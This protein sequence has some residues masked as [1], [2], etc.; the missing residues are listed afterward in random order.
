MAYKIT[1][2][3]L[4][5]G[6]GFRPYVKRIADAM[7]I[8][9]TVRNIAGVVDIQLN[10]DNDMMEAFIKR[11][12][13]S[14][15]KGAVI[16]KIDREVIAEIDTTCFSI[17][18]SE[19]DNLSEL[20]FVPMDIAT[21]PECIREL[22]DS[23]NRRYRHPFIS[24]VACGPRYSI[25]NRTPYDRSN[26]VMKDFQMCDRCRAEYNAISD[27]R[28]YAQTIACPECGPRL[29]FNGESSN[30]IEST[31]SALIKGRIVAV[32]DTGGY[33]FACDARNA[34]AVARL[35]EIKNREAKPFAVMFDSID[36]IEKYAEVSDLELKLLQSPARPIVL[37]TKILEVGDKV[38][39]KVATIG[40]MLPQN[41]VQLLLA[42]EM[43]ALVM[44]S[45]NITSEPIIIDD[46]TMC[47][48]SEKYDF[49]ILSHDRAILT[50]LDDS[51]V[52]VIIDK[53]Q[54]IRR[55]RGYVPEPIELGSYATR[56]ML[57]Y[58]GDLKACF[59][60]ARNGRVILSQYFGDLM[61]G[62]VAKQ[63][64]CSI[65]DMLK[66]YKAKKDVTICDMHPAYASV[67][68]AEQEGEPIKVQ[69]HVAHVMSV[70]AEHGITGNYTGFAFDGTGFGADGKIWGGEVFSIRDNEIHRSSHLQNITV[71]GGD[72][73]AKDAKNLLAAYLFAAGI[74]DNSDN[75]D[76]IKKAIE[77]RVNV[78]ETSSMGRLFDAVSALLEVCEYNSYEGECAVMLE[79]LA[80]RTQEIYPLKLDIENVK[81]LIRDIYTAKQSGV[82][83]AAIARGFHIAVAQMIITEAEKL[84]ERRI[85]LSGGVFANRLLL[86]KIYE[87]ADSKGF[88]IYVNERVPMGDG[89]ISLGQIWYVQRGMRLCV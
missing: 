17:I 10:A 68:L 19:E 58:G 56:D 82:S 32:K 21:C 8:S 49:D 3:G 65:V 33:H 75:E 38:C 73:V 80:M 12:Y 13:W 11:L 18:D 66:L 86:E 77:H 40:A 25:I 60:I 15:P 67:Q 88:K 2:Y 6:V 61:D 70:A 28:C 84:G 47:K 4:V 26:T 27:N 34:S 22:M 53:V 55:A 83:T 46:D 48:L 37:L 79:T 29:F 52:R 5:Q 16:E 59:A 71:V 89:G 74:N 51:I 69:H 81:G 35:R 9:G 7:S 78:H 24:C 39:E 76:L 20:P 50:P 42:Q 87:L 36:T 64:S 54:V 30:A 31:I 63:Y 62:K 72:N 45:G 44:T 41:P 85:L 14:M 1:V 57:A 43:D 23:R